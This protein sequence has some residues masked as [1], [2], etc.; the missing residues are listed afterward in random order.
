VS[1]YAPLA[2][3]KAAQVGAHTE[4]TRLYLVAIKY[5]SQ[6]EPEKLL[7][8]Y[9]AYAYECYLTNQIEEAI[10][11]QT[12]VFKGQEAKGHTTQAGNSLR[13]LSRLSWFAGR[14]KDAEK[15]GLQAITLLE[16]QEA[17]QAKAMAWSNMSQLKMLADENDEAN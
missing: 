3:E 4:A 13:F 16:D 12:K 11:Y 15:Y 8:L 9:E 17:S 6:Q 2:A 5:N 7:H 1:K 14:T 10:I